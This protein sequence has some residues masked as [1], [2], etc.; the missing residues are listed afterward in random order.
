MRRFLTVIPWLVPLGVPAADLPDL[1]AHRWVH[2]VLVIDTPSVE[3][4]AYR[5]QAAVLLPD[6]AGWMERELVVVTRTG[7]KTFR[8]RLVGKDGGVKLDRAGVV[9]AEG[10]RAVID[11]MPMRRAEAARARRS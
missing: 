3:H 4:E 2:R 10:L 9:S 6:W 7:G 11:A 5:A 8:V 1:T